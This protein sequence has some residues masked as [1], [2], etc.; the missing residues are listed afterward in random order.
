MKANLK[1]LRKPRQ[2]STEFKQAIVAEFE[3]GRLSVQQLSILH[4]LSRVM[5]Y[6]WI[7][8]FSTFNEKGFRIIEMK[9]STSK[10]VKELEKKVKELERM[11]GQKQI[12]IDFLEKM[13][14]IAKEEL[15]I[16]IK[17]NFDTP[18]S[19]GSEKTGKK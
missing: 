8:K 14:E 16:D 9:D 10:K 5:I 15:N 13:M 1:N 3:G 12:K 18:R 7:H 4:S 17:K 19:T 11:V 2:F 6:N